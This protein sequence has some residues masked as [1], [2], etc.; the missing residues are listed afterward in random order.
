MRPTNIIPAICCIRGN[1][2]FFDCFYFIAL[3]DDAAGRS[4][5]HRNTVTATVIPSFGHFCRLRRDKCNAFSDKEKPMTYVTKL[6]SDINWYP[7]E[8]VLTGSVLM[9]ENNP[10]M[11]K[12]VLD[13]LTPDNMK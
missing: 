13:R 9:K 12:T 11:I 2:L 10:D 1:L 8:K 5:L 7:I 3:C 4:L 6:S